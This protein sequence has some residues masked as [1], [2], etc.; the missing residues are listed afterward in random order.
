MTDD[1]QADR[2]AVRTEKDGV[3]V[4]RPPKCHDEFFSLVISGDKPFC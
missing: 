4:R 2:E 1:M 3:N